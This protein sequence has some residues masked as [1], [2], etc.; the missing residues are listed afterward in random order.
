MERKRKA[1]ILILITIAASVC[2]LF[3]TSLILIN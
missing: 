3:A 1:L 2:G